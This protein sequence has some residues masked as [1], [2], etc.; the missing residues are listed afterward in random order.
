MTVRGP[1]LPPSKPGVYALLMR[2]RRAPTLSYDRPTP[3]SHRPRL[4]RLPDGFEVD[5][6]DAAVYKPQSW[7]AARIAV[8]VTAAIVSVVVIMLM[9]RAFLSIGPQGKVDGCFYACLLTMATFIAVIFVIPIS[10]RPNQRTVF[11]CDA[12][13]IVVTG[14]FG[15][16]TVIRRERFIDARVEAYGTDGAQ[17]GS[18]ILYATSPA[19][20]REAGGPRAERWPRL[21]R[22]DRALGH[23]CLDRHLVVDLIRVLTLL[24]QEFAL[25]VNEQSALQASTTRGPEDQEIDQ[26]H[27]VRDHVRF[28]RFPLDDRS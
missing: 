23:R 6:P 17:F 10:L 12:I 24:R 27:H 11:R 14:E 19:A 16:A 9:W 28:H 20:L 15:H 2:L 7:N 21:G 25:P 5:F 18:L 4:R 8:L 1:L 22:P 3:A 13:G 26:Y